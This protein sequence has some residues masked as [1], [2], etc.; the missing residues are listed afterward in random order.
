MNRTNSK[1][2]WQAFLSLTKRHLLVF[3]KNVPTVIFTLMVPMAVFAVYVLFLRNIEIGQLQAQLEEANVIVEKN[4]EL[5]Y[6]LS[7]IADTFMIAGVLSVSAITVSLNS[8]F[9]MV[10][11]KESGVA[12]D[13]ISSPISPSLITL[14]YLVFNCIIT[15]LTN[16]LVFI[17]CIIFLAGYGAYMP[18]VGYFFAIIGVIA[19]SSISASLINFFICSFIRSESVLSPLVAI[20][21]AAI[22]FLIG[23]YLPA[24]MGPKY[25]EYT[26]AF[27]P[28]TYFTG[29]FRFCFLTN[30]MILLGKELSLVPNGAEFFEQMTGG[31]FSFNISFF[32]HPVQPWMM[33]IVSLGFIVLFAFLNGFFATKNYMNFL[34]SKPK[35]A[36]KNQN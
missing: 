23:A 15:F 30:P 14:S 36:K 7:G 4:S 6:H 20:V 12:K 21:S 1:T 25:I 9:I 11:D 10:R 8:N 17:I 13:F 35:K 28:G 31:T 5:W 29:L 27:F 32:G 26:T 3:L 19:L 16:F 22:G 34:K 24:D 2:Q 18:G 33:V